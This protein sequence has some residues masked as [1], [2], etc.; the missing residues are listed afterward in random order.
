MSSATGSGNDKRRKPRRGGG[1]GTS[2]GGYPNK[3]TRRDNKATRETMLA[4]IP[5]DSKLELSVE[6]RSFVRNIVT[7]KVFPIHK[8]ITKGEVKRKFPIAITNAFEKMKMDT[9]S[10]KDRLQ[11]RMYAPAI[12]DCIQKD[13]SQRRSNVNKFIKACVLGKCG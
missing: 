8:C 11:R 13:V 12:L 5:K 3:K 9:D 4:D 2:S 1:G 7:N 10:T 6:E